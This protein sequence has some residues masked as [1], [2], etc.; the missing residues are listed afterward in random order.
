MTPLA[1]LI[2]QT[3]IKPSELARQAAISRQ[4]LLRLMK[5]TMEPTRPVAVALARAAGAVLCGTCP[6]GSYSTSEVVDDRAA[7]SL[8]VE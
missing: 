4:H 7:K 5:G 1:V 3:C 6:L 8:V 2:T